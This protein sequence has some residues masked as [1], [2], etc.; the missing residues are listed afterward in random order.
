MFLNDRKAFT[1]LE[2]VFVIV[3]IGVLSA[4]AIPKFKGVSDIAYDAKGQNTLSIVMSALSTERQKNIL[5]GSF[6]PITDLGDATY[7]FNKF[8]D[9]N[10]N[11][12]L[13]IPVSN[14]ASG[15]TGCWKRVSALKYEYFFADSST[16][17]EGKAK[18]KLDKSKLV[19]DS[20]AT[21]C[22]R[23]LQ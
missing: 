9:A 13:D 20:D 15:Q 8:N 23:L 18:F 5:K 4:I 14:C 17:T 12:I 11:E 6:T 3:I 22:N 7:A 16:G 21:D 19:C 10:G 2:L 1:V